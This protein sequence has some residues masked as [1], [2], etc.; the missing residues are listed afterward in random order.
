MYVASAFTPNGDGLNDCFGVHYWG[1]PATFDMMIYDKWGVPV[2]HSK[3]I[4]ECWDG[5]YKGKKQGSG[6]YV[7]MITA[8]S[9]C[10]QDKVFKKGTV[11]LIR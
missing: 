11:V 4:N 5:T 3:N 2:Y 6:T 8:T 1:P 10:G 9:V 7:Y